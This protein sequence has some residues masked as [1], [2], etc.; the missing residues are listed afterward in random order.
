MGVLTSLIV[1]AAGQPDPGVGAVSQP[2]QGPGE[3]A[4][5]I[6]VVVCVLFFLGTRDK[7]GEK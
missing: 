1:L 7:K 5:A 2:G 6:I 4:A 3:W